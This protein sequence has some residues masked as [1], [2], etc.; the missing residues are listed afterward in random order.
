MEAKTIKASTMS[1]TKR[2]S[3]LGSHQ[4]ERDKYRSF[5]KKIAVPAIGQIS[6]QSLQ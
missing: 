5:P 2:Q 3:I 6:F 4:V 1:G